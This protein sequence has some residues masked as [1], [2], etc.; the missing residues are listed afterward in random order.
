MQSTNTYLELLHERGI[1]GLSLER[2]YRQLFN[3]NLYL[4]AYGRIYRNA[5]ATTP[6]VTDE[7]VDA[8]SLDKIDTIIEALRLE[9][10]QWKPARRTYIPKKDG[11]QRPLGLP[12]WSDKLL[13]EV[14]RMI[15]DAYFD[16]QFSNHS[17][18]FRSGRG[19]HTALREIYY[20]WGGT[21]WLIEGDI[22]QCFNAL[23]HELLL[24]T[25]KEHIHDGRFIHLIQKLLDAGYLEDWKFNR[26][27]SGVPQGSIASPI[28]S[29]ILPDK[30]DKYVE[31]VFDPVLHQRRQKETE[32]RVRKIET[33]CCL[34]VQERAGPGSTDLERANSTLAVPRSSR[35]RVPTTQV[36]KVCG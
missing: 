8:M 31:T 30:L 27:L 23:D 21:I 3:K 17:H 24:S 33:S 35:S 18:G 14:I 13:A 26:T 34:P 28:L 2:V 9:R 32:C 36:R 15:L 25:L 10:Y 5:G 7:T 11:R 6:G 20:A 22:S 19:C 29:N 1:K 12:T 4:T 16:G